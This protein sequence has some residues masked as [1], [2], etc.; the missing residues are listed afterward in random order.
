MNVVVFAVEH[1]L[2]DVLRSGPSHPLVGA[3]L[4]AGS[5]GRVRDVTPGSAGLDE[6]LGLEF[7]S[8]AHGSGAVLLRVRSPHVSPGRAPPRLV[9]VDT[10]LDIDPVT[11]DSGMWHDVVAAGDTLALVIADTANTHAPLWILM[12][13]GLP[14][15]GAVEPCVRA[16][17]WNSWCTLAGGAKGTARFL[18]E[19]PDAPSDVCGEQALIGRLRELYGE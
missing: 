8:A 2:G 17:L 14:V 5:Y 7:E 6:L 19:E 3:F 4:D 9:C 16:D 10:P 15:M 18:L 11:A 12:G 1:E 13:R